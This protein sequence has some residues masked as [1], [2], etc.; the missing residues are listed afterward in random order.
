MVRGGSGSGRPAVIGQD[1]DGKGPKIRRVVISWRSVADPLS[2][3]RSRLDPA[4][5]HPSRLQ[6]SSPTASIQEGI[7]E[8][9][10]TP[11]PLTTT[12]ITTRSGD[13]T[14][15]NRI[16]ADATMTWTSNLDGTI[17]A[18]ELA[19]LRRRSRGVAMTVTAGCAVTASARVAT[20][21]WRCDSDEMLRS[22]AS[23]AEAI[24]SE[25]ALAVLELHHGGR[26]DRSDDRLTPVRAAAASVGLPVG[27]RTSRQ[28]SD[29]EI[30]ATIEA[31]GAAALRAI[32]AGFNGVEIHGAL[33]SLPHQFF[34]PA[35][36]RR[37]DHWGGTLE[38]RAAFPIAVLE[39]VQK[40]VRRNATVPFAIG[41]R[42]SPLDGEPH[43]FTFDDTLA[44]VDGLATCRPKWLHVACGS[45][46][47]ARIRGGRTAAG[48]I[49]R[50][51]ADRTLVIGSGAICSDDEAARVLTDGVDLVAI[52]RIESHRRATDVPEIH[53]A[54]VTAR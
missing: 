8:D 1:C 14:F 20:S 24:R 45:Y 6:S 53:H 19:L 46:F 10:S 30:E 34:S 50:V 31:Y 29:I 22:L 28:M 26:L 42:L 23:A 9:T 38:G 27:P 17:T 16:V 40:V 36:N 2:L 25:G 3:G 15:R 54:R 48:R 4:V 21:Q 47:D 52:E 12:S 18:D 49:A 37:S 11:S 7:V 13:I 44:L 43:G 32:H 5:L 33:G 35:T 39:E 41:Y 51:A